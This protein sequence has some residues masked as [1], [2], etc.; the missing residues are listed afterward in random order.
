MLESFRSMI[1][2]REGN[3]L[4]FIE[5]PRTMDAIVEHRFVYRPGT[6]GSMADQVERRSMGMH[7]ER[8]VRDGR[9]EMKNDRYSRVK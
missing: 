2:F 5:A 8:L 7:L 6:G 4:R 1:D 3:L 9:V